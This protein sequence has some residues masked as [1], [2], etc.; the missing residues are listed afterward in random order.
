M[1]VCMYARMY[2]FF[3]FLPYYIYDLLMPLRYCHI[4]L[5]VIMITCHTK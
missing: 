3:T 2:S 1:C 4:I 5:I